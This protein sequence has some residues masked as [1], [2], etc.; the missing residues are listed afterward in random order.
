MIIYKASI[1]RFHKKSHLLISFQTNLS[2]SSDKHTTINLC[3][4][5]DLVRRLRRPGMCWGPAHRPCTLWRRSNLRRPSL[6]WMLWWR[7]TLLSPP[8][9]S[10]LCG[11]AAAWWQS[12]FHHQQPV[13]AH[14]WPRVKTQLSDFGRWPR[15][16]PRVPL[17]SWRHGLGL[18]VY[19][20]R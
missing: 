3:L 7:S 17:P 4:A 15:R 18:F 12:M 9:M 5:V 20:P 13:G 16:C 19:S 14:S 10:F 11:G 2:G 8:A 1:H 6:E